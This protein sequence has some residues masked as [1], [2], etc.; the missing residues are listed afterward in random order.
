MT[1]PH[2]EPTREL[3]NNFFDIQANDN[4]SN[5]LK[6]VLS[7]LPSDFKFKIKDY[8]GR[9]CWTPVLKAE[10]TEDHNSSWALKFLDFDKIAEKQLRKR[11][12][13]IDDV[14]KNEG[15][16]GFNIS[17]TNIATNRVESV[18][19]LLKNGKKKKVRFIAE[20]YLDRFLSDYLHNEAPDLKK[21]IEVSKGV[22]SGL[23][24]LHNKVKRVHGDLKPDN[25]GYTMDGTIKLS[26][27]GSSTL[28]S[29]FSDRKRDNIGFINT[30]SPECF[31]DNS[32]PTF[33]SDIFSFGSL[34]YKLFTN[35]YVLED[36]FSNVNDP[37][38]YIN[39]LD[40]NIANK[41]IRTKI[42][43][44]KNKIPKPFRK[45]L[46][47]CLDFNK[48][49]RLDNVTILKTEFNKAVEDLDNWKKTK[50][51][52]R[53]SSL[54]VLILVAMAFIGYKA[55]TYEPN[56]LSIPK[57]NLPSV[58]YSNSKLVEEP[59]V[60]DE[61]EELNLEPFNSPADVSD[62]LCKLSTN[63][64]F[65]AYL[66]KT[67]MQTW[68]YFGALRYDPTTESQLQIYSSYK[69]KYPGGDI[70]S[71]GNILYNQVAKSIEFTVD[72]VKT[73]TGDI[74]LEDFCVATRVGLDKLNEARRTANSF[75]FKEYI[76]SKD[77]NGE[78]IIS[79]K[80]RKFI[81]MW[82]RHIH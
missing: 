21:I 58:I 39:S 40:P 20:E 11:G 80:E 32:H 29:Y 68:S 59:L 54:P 28:S 14:L 4:V 81:E 8:L 56:E 23:D 64:R 31:K 43:I 26:D 57:E 36:E 62:N 44:N 16:N 73:P 71:S 41:I 47:K 52:L 3:D 69:S 38:S 9:G 10:D 79:E 76:N 25:I 63:N 15:L 6:Y 45:L 33:R 65:V 46:S 27:F 18:E 51:Y 24:V 74:D 48:Y 35:K 60:F 37:V 53:K 75:E 72:K 42:K 19:I 22:I 55:E 17:Y 82:L 34:L 1:V 13:T 78:L 66:L 12:L 30:R 7:N 67:Y 70:Y 5:K 2:A 49:S 61:R 50:K 77:S